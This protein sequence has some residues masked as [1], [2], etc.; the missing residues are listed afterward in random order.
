MNVSAQTKTQQREEKLQCIHLLYL[1]A[2]LRNTVWQNSQLGY[3][4]YLSTLSSYYR[5]LAQ[6]KSKFKTWSIVSTE[7]PSLQLNQHKSVTVWVRTEI[8]LLFQLIYCHFK[9]I[10]IMWVGTCTVCVCARVHACWG[11]QRTAF[12]NCPLALC[13][14]SRNW[15]Q[16]IRLLSSHVLGSH[17]SNVLRK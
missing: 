8:S 3:L 6:E 5:F 16:V 4:R 13:V 7:F 11:T 9:D 14:S 15:T 10:V 12:R 17:C 2:R 1:T